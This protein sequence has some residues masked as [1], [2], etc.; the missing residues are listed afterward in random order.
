MSRSPALAPLFAVAAVLITTGC[1]AIA[2]KAAEKATD[3]AV[4][5]IA[6]ANGGGDVDIDTDDGTF[7]IQTDDGSMTVDDEGNMVIESDEGTMTFESGQ[8]LPE[9]FPDVP[10]PSGLTIESTSRMDSG[11]GTVAYSVTGKVDGDPAEVFDT[12]IGDLEAVGYE[13]TFRSDATTDGAFSGTALMSK[14]DTDQ[15]NVNVFEDAGIAY[16]QLLVTNA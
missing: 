10:L 9:D 1:G 6:E 4:E 7:S 15:I 14:G 11:D 8:E 13:S 2:D 3:E 16:V 12:V 5:Q